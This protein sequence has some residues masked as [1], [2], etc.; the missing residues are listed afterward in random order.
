MPEEPRAE[1]TFPVAMKPALRILS[2]NRATKTAL[3]FPLPG[4]ASYALNPA[5]EAL[6]L[7]VYGEAALF[8]GALMPASSL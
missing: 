4:S 2:R 6:R 1:L 7:T 8:D 3:P 5:K